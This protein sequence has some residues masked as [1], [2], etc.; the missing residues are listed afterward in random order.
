MPDRR[1]KRR[2]QTARRSDTAGE[3]VYFVRAGAAVKIGRTAN[4]AA[5]LRALGTASAVPLELLAA[6]PGGREREVREHR[7]WRH[8]HVRGEW[9]RADGSLVRYAREQVAGGPAPEPDP[10]LH[11]Q[12]TQLRRV[13]A[14]LDPAV[15]AA[16]QG[17]G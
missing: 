8:L 13:L 4:L 15:L 6:V 5:R 16:V 14:A 17:V 12:V 1:R 10:R 11:A 3:V 7:R 2:P 9:F